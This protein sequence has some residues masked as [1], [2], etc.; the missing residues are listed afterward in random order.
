[1][2]SN[3][4]CAYSKKQQDAFS[5]VGN[6]ASLAGINNSGVGF[7]S[8]QRFL[9]KNYSSHQM[10][11][12]TKG[13]NINFGVQFNYTGMKNFNDFSLG[14]AAGKKLSDKIDIGA[15]I[16]FNTEKAMLYN[17]K[18]NLNFESGVLIHLTPVLN[19][20]IHLYNPAG[21][22]IASKKEGRVPGV[23]K[24]GV[25]YDA[26]DDFHISAEMLKEEGMPVSVQVGFQYQYRKKFFTRFCY[27]NNLQRIC[28]VAGITSG[29]IRMAVH[30]SSHPQLGITPGISVLLNTVT[31]KK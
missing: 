7:F 26:S 20:G 22:I 11:F 3:S 12:V 24:F 5:F 1:M 21:L 10:V 8:E 15:Q 16:N 29:K 19:V 2:P 31:K 6:Q 23:Y 13:R 9:I 18:I 25:G 14:L 28:F 17:R 27:I 30:C 4:F